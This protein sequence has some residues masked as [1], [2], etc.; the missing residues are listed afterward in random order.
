M[1]GDARNERAFAAVEAMLAQMRPREDAHAR[2]ELLRRHF[3]SAAALFQAGAPALER[4]GLRPAD[5]LLLSRM[6]ELA[7]CMRR[8][9]FD[10]RPYIGTLRAASPYLAAN[11]HGLQLERFY[12]FCIDRQGKLKARVLLQEGTED[13]ALFSLKAMLA[14]VVRV[15]PYAVLV[16][17]N[18]PGR[19]LRP[20]QEDIHCTQE[21]L[22]ALSVVGIPLLDHVIIAGEQAVS[23]RDNGFI[24][25]RAW[26]AQHPNHR[27]L[28][29][30]LDGAP[31]IAD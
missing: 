2:T 5:A 11:F 21:A 18:H 30:W 29:H 28:A 31:E 6:P 19:T 1:N 26:L 13:G 3:G 15:E 20:S 17:H 22:R 14:Q 9:R 27:L 7:R 25:A 8:A 16:S 12:L 4:L 24:P 10:R 23:L